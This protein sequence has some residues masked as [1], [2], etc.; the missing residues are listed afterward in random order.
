MT[1]IHDTGFGWICPCGCI[2]GCSLHEHMDVVA[3][4]PGAPDVEDLRKQVAEARRGCEELDEAGEHPEWHTYDMALDDAQFT[5]YERLMTAGFIRV[6]YH[7]HR[8]NLDFEGSADA[9]GRQ[10]RFIQ[11]IVEDI[12]A[13]KKDDKID[14]ELREWSAK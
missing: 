12:R 2:V 10:K 13:A 7:R 14:P 4:L 9:L 3:A 8:H 1:E 5:A 11:R 6:G